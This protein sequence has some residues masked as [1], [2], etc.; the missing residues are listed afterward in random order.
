MDKIIFPDWFEKLPAKFQQR[1]QHADPCPFQLLPELLHLS[2]DELRE[3]CSDPRFF[4][5]RGYIPQDDKEELEK[6]VRQIMREAAWMRE[7]LSKCSH[8]EDFSHYKFIRHYGSKPVV[9]HFS[10]DGGFVHQTLEDFKKSFVDKFIV[11]EDKKGKLQRRSFA[12]AWLENSYTPKFEEARFLPGCLPQDV[13]DGIL[14]IWQGWPKNL[15]VDVTDDR[16]TEPE[17]CKKFLEH[18]RKNICGGNI[19]VYDYLLGWMAHALL[20]PEQ[21]CEIAIVLRGPQGS[22]KSFWAKRLMEFFEPHALTLNKPDQLTGS[23]NKHLQDKCIVFADEAFFAG[24]KQH[25]ATLKTLITD[26][27]IFIHP[28]G[29]DGFMAKKSFRVIIASNDEH[30][31]R[32]EEDDRRYLVL[33]VNAG[34]KNQDTDYF[35]AIMEEW[36]NGGRSDLFKWLRGMHWQQII[37]SGAWDARRRPKTKALEKQKNLSLPVT[38]AI[39]HQM[40]HDGELPESYS[41]KNGM[42]F[43]AT[44]LLVDKRKLEPVEETALGK[45]IHV[46]A[47]ESAKNER[48]YLGDGHIRRQYRG[49]WLPTLETCRQRWEAFLGRV[50]EWP[51]S[52]G[53]WG[54]ERPEKCGEA[55]EGHF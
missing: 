52:V 45:L 24:N 6:F 40:L 49:Y 27:E 13:P 48:V 17:Y 8:F 14:N 26:H 39:I 47:G 18:T 38:Q 33:D 31:I 4:G 54:V 51:E 43:V 55:D 46:L 20:H 37:E 11:V 10:S 36:K 44:R 12:E 50:V 42:V 53:T 41:A 9:V 19:E 29:V 3:A 35:G 7:T 34:D 23:F 25:A 30:V 32:A 5:M 1:M 22:G 21:L 16:S 2:P 15:R 28:K